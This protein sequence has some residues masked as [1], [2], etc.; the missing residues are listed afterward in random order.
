ML[1]F[2]D[3]EK[4]VIKSWDEPFIL[5]NNVDKIKDLLKEVQV[6]LGLMSWAVW[7][8]RDLE[9]FNRTMRPGIE[10]ALGIKFNDRLVWSMDDWA[11]N[12]FRFHNK[13]VSRADLF[14]MF[15]K[16][17]VLFVLSGCFPEFNGK[18]VLLVDDAVEHNRSVLSVKNNCTVT[19]KNVLQLPDE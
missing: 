13:K 2:L 17:E 10:E 11:N 16:Q 7:D 4:T 6:E 9:I 14:D 5:W 19:I 3:L 12:V 8:A 1:V 18:N 15:G